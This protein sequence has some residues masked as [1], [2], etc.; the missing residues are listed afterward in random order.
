[1][2]ELNLCTDCPR[3]SAFLAEVRQRHPDYHARPVLPFGDPQARLLVVGL[4]PGMHGANRTGRPF[5]G[6]YA[7]ILLYETLHRYG[8]ADRPTSLARDDGLHLIDCRITNAVKCLPP[9]NKPEL[10]EI[11]LCNRYLADEL[12][13]SPQVCVILALGQIA[14]KAVLTAVGLKQAALPFTH[15]ARHG[16]PDGKVLIDSYHCSR[17]NTQTKRLTTAG[18]HNVFDIIRREL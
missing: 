17:Y 1:M 9:E 4:A 6:D 10:A 13:N 3:L 18:F 12:K 8:F 14:H 15:G 16:L 11:R 2:R 7:G 5:T